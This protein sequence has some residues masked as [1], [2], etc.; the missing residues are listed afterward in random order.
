[1]KY[2][3]SM[4]KDNMNYKEGFCKKKFKR[5]YNTIFLRGI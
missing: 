3:Y 4:N 5:I 1:M 2:L